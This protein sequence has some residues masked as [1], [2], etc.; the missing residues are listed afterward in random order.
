MPTCPLTT[1][2]AP[3]ARADADAIAADHRLIAA[4]P[5]L[6]TVLDALPDP[7]LVLNPERQI[8]FGNRAAAELAGYLGCASMLG[9]RP[10]ELLACR[11]A[12]A[13]VA[14]C[15][16]SEVCRTCGA[17]Q[18]I[19]EAADGARSTQECRINREPGAGP[20]A[21]DF[22]VT[23][24]PFRL[25][26]REFVL[27]VAKDIADEKR[28]QVLERVFFHDILNTAGGISSMAAMLAVGDLTLDEV[29][30]DLAAAS[31]AL[32]Q[33]IRSQR[34]LL[35]AEVNALATEPAALRSASLLAGVVHTFRNHEVARDR[36]L[37][38]ADSSV[39]CPLVSDEALLSR[40]LGNLVK[41]ALEASRPGG[42]VTLA[43]H[44]DDATVTFTC[45][46]L[47]T[48]PRRVQLQIFQRSFSTKGPSRGIGTYSIKLLAERYLGGRVSFT[49]D[50]ATG[51]TFRVEL[52]RRLAPQG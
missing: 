4:S 18:A 24:S 41:N 39:D 19:L 37:V 34:I 13:S 16:T 46:N 49:S 42:T 25:D 17:V 11:A 30:A 15:G 45:H 8:V 43:C 31:E 35:A 21:L 36:R 7:I 48:I 9:M 50:A 47:G 51:T 12:L 33:E 28:R 27:F 20:D 23:A 26:D 6:V 2:F 22:R 40:V 38:I 14:G 10:G 29:K 3:A 5:V 52:P 44:A 1:E 32:V